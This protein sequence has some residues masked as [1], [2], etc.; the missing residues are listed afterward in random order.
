MYGKASARSREK[1]SCLIESDSYLHF[2]LIQFKLQDRVRTCKGEIGWFK[3]GF[4]SR[5]QIRLHA[6]RVGGRR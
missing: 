4:F 6:A 2:N 1:L 3:K 5:W